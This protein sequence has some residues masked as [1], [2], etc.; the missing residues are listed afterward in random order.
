M[1]KRSFVLLGFMTF[2]LGLGMTASA[3][4]QVLKADIPFEFTVGKTKLPA[5]EYMIILPQSGD[6]ATVKFKGKDGNS[7]AMAMTNWVNS[8]KSGF[9]D[10]LTFIKSG[11]KY[12]L[13]QVHVPGSELGQEVLKAKRL[14]GELAQKTVELKPAKS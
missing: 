1:K 6:A 13:Y 14:G 3:Q 7:F 5:G 8:K 4:G 12:F 9:Q 11:D 2:V 10:G